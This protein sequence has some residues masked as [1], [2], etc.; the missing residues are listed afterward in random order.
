MK[1]RISLTFVGPGKE[2]MAATLSRSGHT[3]S[4]LMDK[5]LNIESAKLMFK[6]RVRLAINPNQWSLSISNTGWIFS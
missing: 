5:I 4:S 6:K 2:N 1:L 3:S